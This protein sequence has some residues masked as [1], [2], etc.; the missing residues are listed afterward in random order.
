VPIGTTGRSTSNCLITVTVPFI[1]RI[2]DEARS[3]YF[4]SRSHP[5]GHL[6]GH[7]ADNDRPDFGHPVVSPA[8]RPKILPLL[9]PPPGEFVTWPLKPEKLGHPKGGFRGILNAK[10][11]FF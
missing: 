11:R 2:R 10:N 6:D 5:L 9:E 1:F 7:A 4:A 3:T 8:T